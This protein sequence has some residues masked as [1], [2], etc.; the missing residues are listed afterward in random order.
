ML[1]AFDACGEDIFPRGGGGEREFFVCRYGRGDVRRGCRGDI[2]FGGGFRHIRVGDSL[3]A[4][5]G[6]PQMLFIVGY[7]FGGGYLP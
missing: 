4:R 1:V 2:C 5:G 7:R 6:G 3:A